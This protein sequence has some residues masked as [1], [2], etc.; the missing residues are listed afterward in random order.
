MA[1][2]PRIVV[3]GGGG[4]GA[5]VAYDLALRGFPSIL[6]EKGSLTSGSTGR[7]HGLLHSGARYAV[8]DIDAATECW[9]EAQI[10]RAITRDVIEDNSGIFVAVGDQDTQDTQDTPAYRE[11]FQEGCA[12]VGIPF[13]PLSRAEIKYRIPDITDTVTDGFAVPDASFDAWRLPLQFFASALHHGAIV[14]QFCEVTEI[15]VAHQSVQAVKVYDYEAQREH[16][17]AC[18]ILINAGGVWSGRIAAMIGVTLELNVQAGAMVA[19]KGRVSNSV[20]NRLASPSDG[21]IIVP[22][23]ALSVIGTTSTECHDIDALEP[24]PEEIEALLKRAG[25]LVPPFSK[26]RIHAAWSSARPLA[27]SSQDNPRSI[28]RKTLS[29]DHG[30]RDAI[31]GVFTLIGGKATTLRAMAE[32]L[33]DR[34]C[35]YTGVHKKSETARTPLVPFRS[36]YALYNHAHNCLPVH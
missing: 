11:Q 2:R 31:R 7:H 3:I 36:F 6:L 4:S 33:V 29:I 9:Q 35:A 13:V 8:H 16:R 12:T 15:I 19:V 17:L 23:R 1:P 22:Q 30:E 32:E 26:Q 28:S 21:D 10:L 24:T 20:V 14:R 5:A 27:G 18:D 25:E 34:V